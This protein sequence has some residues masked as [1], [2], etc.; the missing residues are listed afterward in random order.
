MQF[1]DI[2]FVFQ[3]HHVSWC[4]S[5]RAVKGFQLFDSAHFKLD[6]RNIVSRRMFAE[7][8]NSSRQ[9]MFQRV[10][11]RVKRFLAVVV[12]AGFVC[13]L[14]KVSLDFL[15][16]SGDMQYLVYKKCAA[17]FVRL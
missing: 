9:L 15:L 16:D 12:L 4:H 7:L 6:K 14:I 5:P 13:A 1:L 2:Q 17:F 8:S 3:Y 11:S 10:C